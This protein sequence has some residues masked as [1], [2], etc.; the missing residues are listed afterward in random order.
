MLSDLLLFLDCLLSCVRSI[1]LGRITASS[2]HYVAPFGI[3]LFACMHIVTHVH[4]FMKKDEISG[5][6]HSEPVRVLS[7]ARLCVTDGSL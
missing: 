3:F 4:V 5:A 2:F 1:D 7:H 6:L